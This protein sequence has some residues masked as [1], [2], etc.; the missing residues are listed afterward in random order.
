MMTTPHQIPSSVSRTLLP[1]ESGVIITRFHPVVIL[2]PL[3]IAGAVLVLGIVLGVLTKSLIVWLPSLLALVWLAM[4][5]WIWRDDYFVITNHRLL[6]RTGFLTRTVSMIPLGKVTDI[7]FRRDIAGRMIGYGEIVVEA[8]GQ[9][10]ALRNIRYLPY[11]EQLYLE[12]CGLI[13]KDSGDV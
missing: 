1:H 2:R 3:L 5:V 13:F 9:E 8:V 12:I 7:S 10:H 6:L 4:K 11:P